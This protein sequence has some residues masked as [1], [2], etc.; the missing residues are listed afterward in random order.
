[1]GDRSEE[2][3]GEPYMFDVAAFYGKWVDDIADSQDAKG[4]VSDVSPNYWPFYFDNVTW[5]SSYIIIQAT[6]TIN[7]LICG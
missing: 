6:F 7:T 5:P 4:S 3:R 2:S 1:L